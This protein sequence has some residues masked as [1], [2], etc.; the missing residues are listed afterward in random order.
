MDPNRDQEIL[1]LFKHAKNARAIVLC[2]EKIQ[3][4]VPIFNYY[5][6]RRELYRCEFRLIDETDLLEVDE[7][8]PP[9]EVTIRRD[10][11]QIQQFGTLKL[12]LVGFDSIEREYCFL[13]GRVNTQE[14]YVLFEN[15]DDDE[16]FEKK[17]E[18]YCA[19]SIFE[20][21]K[22]SPNERVVHNLKSL[23]KDGKLEVL[24]MDQETTYGWI[25][26]SNDEEEVQECRIIKA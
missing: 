3:K 26:R 18:Q 2:F 23:Q 22:G 13:R 21:S 16:D 8:K 4:I 5:F 19:E 15:K 20:N 25:S 9:K 14:I 17:V 1:D 11:K 12:Y 6:D 24:L 10:A 7:S